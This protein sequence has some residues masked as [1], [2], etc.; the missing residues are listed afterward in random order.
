[1]PEVIED[2]E[3]RHLAGTCGVRIGRVQ[4]VKF[5]GVLTEVRFWYQWETG[6]LHHIDSFEIK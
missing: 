3:I 1:M 4:I 2:R 6:K 5:E